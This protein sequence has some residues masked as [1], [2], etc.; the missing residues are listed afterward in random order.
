[1]IEMMKVTHLPFRNSL[2]STEDLVLLLLNWCVLAASDVP[3][4]DSVRVSDHGVYLFSQSAIL[5]AV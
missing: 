2:P 5:L 3:N 4:F 1:M